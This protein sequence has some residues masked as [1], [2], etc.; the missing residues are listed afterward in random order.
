MNLTKSKVLSTIIIFALCFLIHFGYN[1][2]PNSFTAIFFPV[3]ESIWEHVKMLYTAIILNGIIDFF[4]LKKNN[5]EFNNFFLALFT[6]AFASIFIFLILYLPFYYKIGAPMILNFSILFITIAIIQIINYYIQKRNYIKILNI[7][8]IVLIIITYIIF[9]I[10]TYFP[11]QNEIF[12]D[13]MDERY[14]LNIYRLSVQE[15]NH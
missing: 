9:G 1:I 14:G 10:L 4:I 15:P 12:F 11:I 3:N 8:S 7:V 5:I 6:S 2:F 13:P